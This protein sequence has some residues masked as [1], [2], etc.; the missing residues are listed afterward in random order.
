MQGKEVL[1]SLEKTKPFNSIT[2]TVPGNPVPY[3]RMTQGQTKLMR[4][5][6][7]RLNPA[8]LK[9]KERIRRYLTYKDWVYVCASACKFD[10][11]PKGKVIMDIKIYFASKVHAD[12]DNI[13]KALSDGLFKNDKYVCGSMDFD[14][15]TLNP[16]VEVKITETR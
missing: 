11:A 16:R 2:F 10:R 12:S 7:N 15:D 13:F 6:D 5:P 4:I 14:Y 1:I 3:L 8:A 9:V